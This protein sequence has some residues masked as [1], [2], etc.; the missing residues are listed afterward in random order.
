MGPEDTGYGKAALE[1]EPVQPP[2]Q[3]Q[4]LSFVR[5]GEGTSLITLSG[6]PFPSELG[7]RAQLSCLR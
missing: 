4:T 7:M 6:K 5:A 2:L 3:S 1:D